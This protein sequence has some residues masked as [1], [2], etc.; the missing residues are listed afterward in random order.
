MEE[1]KQVEP[2]EQPEETPI[3]EPST[4]KPLPFLE[5]YPDE[6]EL[7][8][9]DLKKEPTKIQLF[10]RK[11]LIWFG[12]VAVA[13]LAGFIT[14]Y[15]TLYRPQSQTVD[16]LEATIADLEDQLTSLEAESADLNQQLGV[17]EDAVFHSVLLDVMT[18]AYTARLAL[19]V[20]DTLAA[21]SALRNTASKL[22]EIEEQ[23][24]AFDTG[25]AAGLPQRISLIQTN[26]DRDVEKAIADADL[27]IDD[28]QEVESALFP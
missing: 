8:G 27:L 1:D 4:P 2:Q 7:P 15:L 17:L 6:P 5:S 18:D 20:E 19:T 21:K 10:M 24:A 28:L 9:I 12:V 22:A 23:L 3:D 25:L 13:F 14:F 16:N 11:A 26:I